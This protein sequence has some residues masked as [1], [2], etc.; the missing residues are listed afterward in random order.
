MHENLKLMGIRFWEN[1]TQNLTF[2][3]H[4]SEW[5]ETLTGVSRR[6]RILSAAKVVANLYKHTLL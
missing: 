4:P 1:L 5:Q 3:V 6:Q 2:Q